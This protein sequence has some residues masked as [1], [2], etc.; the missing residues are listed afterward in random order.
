MFLTKPLPDEIV[1][2]RLEDENDEDEDALEFVDDV[3]YREEP[4]VGVGQGGEQLGAPAGPH[5]HPQ[6]ARQNKTM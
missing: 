4:A 6:F 2:F 5:H 3:H 1:E